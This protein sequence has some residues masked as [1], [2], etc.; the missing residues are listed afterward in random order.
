MALDTAAPSTGPARYVGQSVKRVEEK[1]R[2]F[3]T[4]T[5]TCD[6]EDGRRLCTAVVT[7]F[8]FLDQMVPA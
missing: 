4:E 8:W 7:T 2:E 5:T 3:L 1:G 6:G